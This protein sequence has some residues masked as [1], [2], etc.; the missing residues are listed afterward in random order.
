VTIRP[1]AAP[2]AHAS[3]LAL[4]WVVALACHRGSAPVPPADRA[5]HLGPASP[6][7][8]VSTGVLVPAGPALPPADAP[9]A[10]AI[11]P[12]DPAVYPWLGDSGLRVP[13]ASDTLER[14]FAPPAGFERVPI[15]AG[16]FGAWLRGLPLAATGTAV[17]SFRGETI[18]E[19]TH[20][21]VA[22]VVAI[23]VGTAD[24][25]QCADS[26]IRLHAEWLW[27]RG[28]RDMEYRAA[29][30]VAM[31][32]ARWAKGERLVAHGTTIAWEPKAA[33]GAVDHPSFRKYLD[34]VFAWAN[35]GS[36]AAQ[37]RRVTVEE[38][39]PG[40][41]AVLP[42]SPGHAVLVLDMA[43]TQDGRR[44]AL[45]GQGF[46]PAQSFHVLRAGAASAWFEIDPALGGVTTPFWPAVFP[47]SSLR[48]LDD[49]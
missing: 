37:A 20:P 41:F 10:P 40:D 34:A 8:A 7:A 42:G 11:A 23:D 27:S 39:R 38:L 32:L 24:L 12:F 49:G 3:G 31:P 29:S 25:Q 47:W 28:R 45:L 22:A 30:G 6:N 44:V 9:G 19:A 16:S 15:A 1:T 18:R 36:L 33:P 48:R 4:A 13:A 26:V 17:V 35:T 21:G 46:M 14:R 5:E 43:R 2:L